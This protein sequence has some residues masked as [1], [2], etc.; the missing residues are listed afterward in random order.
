MINQSPFSLHLPKDKGNVGPSVVHEGRSSYDLL[1]T[2]CLFIPTL[3]SDLVHDLGSKRSERCQ[4]QLPLMLNGPISALRAANQNHYEQLL[5]LKRFPFL[6]EPAVLS[7]KIIFYMN[8][9]CITR[10]AYT[11]LL[12]NI[13]YQYSGYNFLYCYN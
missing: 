4:D 11:F 2:G 10:K 1:L 13:N 7:W 6:K 8:S 12:S 9:T 3:C 5:Q